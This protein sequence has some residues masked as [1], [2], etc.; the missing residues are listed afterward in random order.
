MNNKVVRHKAV[1]FASE[2]QETKDQSCCA[3]AAEMGT[4]KQ[5]IGSV[6]K[7][8]AEDYSEDVFQGDVFGRNTV[9]FYAEVEV[10]QGRGGE[11]LRSVAISIWCTT[12][13]PSHPCGLICSSTDDRLPSSVG[14]H[15]IDKPEVLIEGILL[16]LSFETACSGCW[17]PDRICSYPVRVLYRSCHSRSRTCWLPSA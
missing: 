17:W 4:A 15:K 7:E 2:A 9:S 8:L 16:G 13:L 5:W 14:F 6:R 10:L 3:Y 11:N 1:Y 12:T